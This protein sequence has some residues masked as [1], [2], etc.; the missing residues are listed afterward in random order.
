[1]TE[2]RGGPY[3]PHPD[4]IGPY[5][6]LRVLGEGGMGIVYEAEQR[7]TI[8]RKV[9]VKVMKP[10][11]DT[12]EVIAR[13]E[14]ERQALAVME[15]PGIAKVLDAGATEE[16]RP[17]FVMEL[18]HGQPLRDY[19]DARK[20]SIRG[21]LELFVRV[22]HA[23]QHAHHK[24]VIHRD[25]KPS[26]IL[27][28][29]REGTATPRVIDFGIAKATGQR[30]SEVTLVTQLGQALGTPAYMSPEQAEASGLDVD[31]RADVYSLG[32]TLYELL[33]GRL[34][35]DPAEVGPQDFMFQL[36]LRVSDPPT[37][38]NRYRT[39]EGSYRDAVAGFR[40]T[41]PGTLRKELVGDL[42]CI[43]MKA[44]EKDRDRRYD[45]V[46]ALAQ[47][48]QRHLRHEPVW[49]SSPNVV[50]RL[51]KFVRRHRVGVTAGAA[52]V[53]ALLGGSILAT[54]GMIRARNAERIAE[55]EAAV[56]GEIAEFL[57]NIFAF[58]D[59]Y[60]APDT[61]MTVRA[62]LDSGAN[63]IHE[64]LEAQPE[65]RARLMHV[66]GRVYNSLG[67]YTEAASMLEPALAQREA[68][69]GADDLAVADVLNELGESYW[70]QGAYTRADTVL[71]RALVI[72][73]RVLGPSDTLVANTLDN[74]AVV[75]GR[76][77]DCS[78]AER[79]FRR[80][81]DIREAGLGPD[82]P[83]VATSLNNF[84]A[85][86]GKQGEPAKAEPLFRRAL[87][88]WQ[89]RLGPDHLDVATALNNLGDNYL[90]QGRVSEAEPL[91]TRALAIRESRLSADHPLVATSLNNLASCYYRSDNV[92]LAAPLFQRA[93]A[94]WE[95][96]VGPDH[97][98]LQAVLS[99]LGR[100][101]YKLDRL[102]E[103]EPLTRRALAML[104]R[105]ERIRPLDLS[106][107]LLNLGDIYRDQGKYSDADQLY[108][109]AHQLAQ[110]SLPGDDLIPDA[111]E[112][113]ATSRRRQGDAT[114]AD[115]LDARAKAIRD[116]TAAASEAPDAQEATAPS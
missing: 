100:A 103:A 19:A 112:S 93:L 86:Y 28:E 91:L 20:L 76:L 17:Y 71:R 42:D 15:H 78:E 48:L 59:P 36:L 16:G 87:A 12:K 83:D 94:S 92:A 62:V 73:D 54:A 61:V 22:C 96:T 31:M 4:H 102:D 97:P 65:H 107:E 109:R 29:E 51:Q 44:L 14:A 72:R 114:A 27:V 89:T 58:A 10:G 40:G 1:M 57:E 18:V 50:Y 30:L 3:A 115:S 104:E 56:A 80:A 33:V 13:F 34:P 106:V 53:A 69:D 7:V 64:D 46:N 38:S 67:R 11:L 84:A 8:R 47:D 39:L 77:D 75:C 49:A 24:G 5:R 110:D 55:D 95:K 32:V 111:L 88:I 52:V 68:L 85:Y 23:V 90:Q 60:V 98:D 79:L 113:Y 99:N 26:N 9:A 108:R 41:D 6:L 81:L 63:R 25:L 74:L 2:T 116:S 70:G 101:Y 35:I 82:H 105:E 37:P 66:M 43:V 21:R 45:T